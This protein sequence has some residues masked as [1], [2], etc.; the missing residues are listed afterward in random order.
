MGSK[1]L[2]NKVHER[3]IL[4]TE[5]IISLYQ[6]DYSARQIGK[7]ANV[8]KSYINT[9]LRKNNIE[10]RSSSLYWKSHHGNKS[11]KWTGYE[12][13]SGHH[14]M[15]IKKGA[16]SRKLIFDIDI[17]YAWSIFISQKRRCSITGLNLY[18]A[19][20]DKDYE[21]GEWNASLDRIDSS[22]G[23]IN[24]N[25]QWVHKQINQMKWAYSQEYFINTMS[26]IWKFSNGIR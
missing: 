23:Y 9:L 18:F 21:T 25:I 15:T 24:D 11:T 4:T 22:I 3:I 5:E 10:I 19:K 2:N 20:N 7:M 12:E 6:N 17:E 1:G 26:N 8:S 14:W 13:I 16:R